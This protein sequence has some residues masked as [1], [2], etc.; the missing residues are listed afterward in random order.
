MR[1]EQCQRG[2][3]GGNHKADSIGPHQ[4]ADLNQF[5]PAI[6]RMPQVVP[7]E[8]SQQVG[9]GIF[10]PRPDYRCRN[11]EGN[12]PAVNGHAS[13]GD[14]DRGIVCDIERQCNPGD[15]HGRIAQPH[16]LESGQLSQQTAG[17]DGEVHPARPILNTDEKQ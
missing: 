6:L 17:V 2:G 1:D 15:I 8:S 16:P 14:K 10:Q 5:Q 13:D 12:R 11:N 4:I 3:T 7:G 9:A